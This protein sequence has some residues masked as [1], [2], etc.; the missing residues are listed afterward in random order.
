MN[1]LEFSA[2]PRKKKIRLRHRRWLHHYYYHHYHHRVPSSCIVMS[3]A[4]NDNGSTG[5]DVAREP[6]RN[7]YLLL[8]VSQETMRRGRGTKERERKRETTRALFR[9]MR[10]AAKRSVN[11]A[12]TRIKD[13][14]Q[15]QKWILVQKKDTLQALFLLTF[16]LSFILLFT[17]LYSIYTHFALVLMLVL[18]LLSSLATRV[19]L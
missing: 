18:L 12:I 19:I 5:I 13:Y 15:V 3:M 17:H 2:L 6:R 8:W 7:F 10:Q 16:S 14:R 11:R 4:N 1:V 9:Y